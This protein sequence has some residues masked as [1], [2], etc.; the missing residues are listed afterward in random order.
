M[1]TGNPIRKDLEEAQ[2]KRDE[3]LK[4]FNLS[5]V[6]GVRGQIPRLLWSRRLS[7]ESSQD[8][9]LF[10]AKAHNA[11]GPAADIDIDIGVG[12]LSA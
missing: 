2:G 10:G 3:A 5:P 11:V 7:G 4:F 1:M 6:L 12:L 9:C 8:H